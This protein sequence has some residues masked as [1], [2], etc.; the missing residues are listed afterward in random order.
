MHQLAALPGA[1]ADGSPPVHLDQTPGDIVVLS[2]A[3]M[4]LAAL[5]QARAKLDAADFPSLRLAS[6]LHLGDDHSVDHYAE[7]VIAHAKLVVVRLLGGRGY[8]PHGSDEIARICRD[9]DILVTFLPGDDQPDPELAALSTVTAEA[10][11]R[12]WQYGVHG[13]PENALD[14]LKFAASL[15]GFD[16]E[17]R[18]PRPLV[19]AGLYWPGL[20]TP[21]LEAVRGEWKAES[22]VAALVFYRALVQ[23]GNLKAID[24]LI[25]GL[26]KKG[27]NPLPVFVASL[28]DPVAAATLGELLSGAPPDVILNATGFAVSVPGIKRT[29]TPFDVI[30][31]V[32]GD[33]DRPGP[34]ILQV[35]FSGG[36]EH[37]WRHGTR[38]LGPRDIAMNVAL[39]E[40]DGR[41]ISRAVS[42]K[43]L[44]RRDPLT[45]TDI[46]EYEPVADRIEFVS[47]LAANW[48][49][50]RLKPAAERRIALVLANYPNR[51]GRIGNG[52]GLDTPAAT[53]NVLNALKEKGY[54][55][56]D[57]PADGAALFDRLM[58]GPTN[59]FKA[60]ANRNVTETLSMADYQLFLAALPE[61]VRKAVDERWSGAEEDPFFIPGGADGGSFAVPAFRLG[62]AAVC[63]QPARGYNINP[64]DSYHDPDLVP[65]HNYLAFHAWLRR[66]FNA[67]AVVHMG[68]HGNLEW[69]PGK[70]MALSSECFPEAALG[71]LP[72]IYPF[73][74]NDPGE[75]TQAKRR[76]SAV[77][78][79]HLTPPLTRA[80]SY[81]PLR[82]LEQLVD[83]YYE[84]Q[85]LDPRRL[86][87]LK[88]DIMELCQ[89]TGL[90]EDCGISGGEAETQAITKLDNYLC[91]LKEMQIR[92]GLHVFGVTPEGRLLT[93]L[94]V[95]LVRIPRVGARDGE[96]DRGEGQSLLRA[97]C[98]DLKLDFDPLDCEMGEKWTGPRPQALKEAVAE[99]T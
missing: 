25:E 8:W 51:D 87:V 95:A 91:E 3:D 92:D 80:E 27:L 82:N 99:D 12:L 39:P 21:D 5:A 35:V 45:E 65:P 79:D 88:H 77:I 41:I 98:S 68:K 63:L 53:V 69:L 81:G 34:V 61:S 1:I 46:V 54:S 56:T 24:A 96:G 42:F 11:H 10:Q 58:A 26:M 75:G 83:E 32:T 18:E 36:N 44:K 85:D 47:D 59:D 31:D 43:G 16:A 19:R 40:V 76:M 28:K 6:L 70:A 2:A 72:N 49:A 93:D 38:G 55:V 33:T 14:F 17:W 67:D 74:V 23:A 89:Q 4:E 9:R 30:G 22:P 73:I 84:A 50:L 52:V 86:K 64:K 48:A 78:V 13:G 20:E 37:D 97:L 7:D 71:P 29:P 62:N 57:I 15:I 94:L 90:D 66:G 60:L